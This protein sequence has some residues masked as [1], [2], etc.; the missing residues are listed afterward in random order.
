[1]SF[2]D[3]FPIDMLLNPKVY[4]DGE[5]CLH[6]SDIEAFTKPQDKS[7]STY[8][9]FVKKNYMETY[10]AILEAKNL[11]PRAKNL[12]Y[13]TDLAN[14]SIICENHDI[15]GNEILGRQ[16]RFGIQPIVAALSVF[17]F[18]E[19]QN[20]E[21][22]KE[23]ISLLI[24]RKPYDEIAT[25]INKK[26][27]DRLRQ[28]K[29]VERNFGDSQYFS[30]VLEQYPKKKNE[31][32]VKYRY[33]LTKKVEEQISNIQKMLLILRN[34]KPLFSKTI[35]VDELLEVVDYSKLCLTISRRIIKSKGLVPEDIV[36]ISEYLKA[37]KKYRQ[38]NPEYTCCIEYLS[39]DNKIEKYSIDDFEREYNQ[40][41]IEHPEFIQFLE[42]LPKAEELFRKYG[43]DISEI[44]LNTPEGVNKYKQ[45]L[46]REE[47][48]KTLSRAWNV[49]SR[50]DK[51]PM[52]ESLKK[53]ETTSSN[54]PKSEK[55]RRKLEAYQYLE[56]SDYLFKIEGINEFEGYIGYV[57][58]SGKIVFEKFFENFKTKTVAINC[59]T[60][61][62][63][64]FKKLVE[65]SMLSKPQIM[66]GLKKG[67]LSGD[68]ERTY[69]DSKLA[70]WKPK[71]DQSIVGSDYTEEIINFI[72]ELIEKGKLEKREQTK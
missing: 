53:L 30:T 68:V 7:S 31:D 43:L 20:V 35:N 52:D 62:I 57:Y 27:K 66:K 49:F 23:I 24:A 39:H 56:A 3:Y 70:R 11:S 42:S 2:K 17:F 33:F 32:P 61:T 28:L 6:S 21:I 64:N 67:E 9:N 34:L 60:Y 71:I 72:T 45:I 10:L 18:S 59:A 54:K 46:Q 41:L 69:H 55:I 44:P 47:Q 15:D 50:G 58:S 51:T 63:K 5:I 48:M 40:Y 26:L 25:F 4:Y 36:W 38:S 65:I 19:K 37:V 12:F 1:M 14:P 29:D 13:D 8:W 16:L 22:D